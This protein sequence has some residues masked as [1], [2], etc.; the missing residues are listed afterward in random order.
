MPLRNHVALVLNVQKDKNSFMSENPLQPK[1]S[2]DLIGGRFG[3]NIY[4]GAS[5]EWDLIHPVIATFLWIAVGYLSWHFFSELKR[6]E[7]ISKTVF[8]VLF[9]SIILFCVWAIVFSF[10]LKKG[11]VEDYFGKQNEIKLTELKFKDLNDRNIVLFKSALNGDPCEHIDVPSEIKT[12]GMMISFK[13]IRDIPIHHARLEIL[14]NLPFFGITSE[15][16]SYNV[17]GVPAAMAFDVPIITPYNDFGDTGGVS[18]NLEIPN[19]DG[20]NYIDVRLSGD[21]VEKYEGW[22]A[23][24]FEKTGK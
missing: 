10:S 7:L 2:F 18:F 8:L 6:T 14:S 20:P 11:N 21:D 22:G 9:I 1:I 3:C 4:C 16:R 13:N 24:N 5:N 15:G 23:F 17:N 19:N 12:Y